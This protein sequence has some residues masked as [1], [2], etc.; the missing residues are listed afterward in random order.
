M[1]D[2][3]DQN[4]TADTPGDW[5]NS[6]QPGSTAD[7]LN[8]A[9]RA[10]RR[11][12]STTTFTDNA[13]LRA[14]GTSG[15]QDSG[16]VCNDTDD[17]SGLNS[18]DVDNNASIHQDLFVDGDARINGVIYSGVG[19]LDINDATDF[20]SNDVTG[21]ANLTVNTSLTM[22]DETVTYAKMQHMTSGT[23]LGR[24]SLGSGDVQELSLDTD[25]IVMTGGTL[26]T[27]GPEI[28]DVHITSD[29]TFT[30]STLANVTNLSFTVTSGEYYRFK[31]TV[32]FRSD[33]AT[34]GIKLGLTH[35]GATTFGAQVTTMRTASSI[36]IGAITASG[37]SVSSTQVPVV[38]TD[39]IATVEGTILPS[40][41]GN[42]Q[43]QA[44]LETGSAATVT[45]RQGSLA[46]LEKVS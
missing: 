20:N 16:I 12:T 18:L 1:K 45:V 38:D 42:L 22:P 33:T 36:T 30:T 35:A 24:H 23:L 10:P 17:V 21:I 14:D 43:L 26:A 7:A 11:S 29:Q 25:R 13:I 34:V 8:Q 27:V 15:I 19:D 4:F 3:A 2:A 9:G 39:Y 41:N 6:G 31:F 44:A 37:G 5:D 40:S 46:T 32:L 28:G